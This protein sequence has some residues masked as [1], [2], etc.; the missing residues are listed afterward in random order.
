MSN[1]YKIDLAANG[2]P[3]SLALGSYLYCVLRTVTGTVE[4]SFDGQIWQPAAQND[5]F[6]P[7]EPAA[8]QIYFRAT[9]GNAASVN[10]VAGLEKIFIQDTATSIAATEIFG[11]LG[12]A[13]N[14]PGGV[15]VPAC[16]VDGFLQITD[17]MNLKVP[18][19]L[20]GKRRLEVTFTIKSGTLVWLD[21]LDKDGFNF[22]TL[23]PGQVVQKTLD[24]DF[25]VSGSNG[26]AKVMIGQTFSKN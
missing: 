9:N 1:P 8:S 26:T 11:N 16:D 4:I 5:S 10:F 19:T 14:T 25:F 22:M 18:G 17:G 21:V 12:L 20:N 15:G 3:G 7:L 13:K 6:G 24:S 2:A 23:F